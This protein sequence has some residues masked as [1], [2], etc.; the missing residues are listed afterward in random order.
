MQIYKFYFLFLLL[1]TYLGSTCKR[2]ESEDRAEYVAQAESCYVVFP[3]RNQ[4]ATQ[5]W[6]EARNKCL[7]E[8]GDLADEKATTLLQLPSNYEYHIGLRRDEFMWT[9]SG[10]YAFI[11][12]K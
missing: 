9:E 6:Y 4:R 12:K 1:S 10:N 8:G 3:Q 7:L 5:T 11:K 2:Y